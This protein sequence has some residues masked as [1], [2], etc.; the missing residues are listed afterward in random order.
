MPDETITDPAHDPLAAATAVAEQRRA[1]D[2]TRQ[3]LI[4]AALDRFGARGF[5]AASTRE[6]AAGAASNIGSIAYHFG[7]K[8]GLRRAAAE[9]VVEIIRSV[10]RAALGDHGLDAGAPPMSPQEARSAM[11]AGI[12]RMIRFVLVQP[13]A[14]LI[15]RFML[16]EIANPSIALDI[17][18]AGVIEPTHGRFCRLW[19]AATGGD[20]ASEHVRLSVFAFIGQVFY[21]RIGQEIV[22]RR[23]GWK[24]YDAAQADAIAAIVVRNLHACLDAETVLN[25]A[26]DL[27]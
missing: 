7:G 17:I 8:D 25:N 4:E 27:T 1:A 9:Y 23:M 16:R 22:L 18:Y 12:G 26:E 21:F 6:I 20:P 15:V 3:S 14:R 11:E 24:A 5:E 2:A 19:A 13:Q 10:A